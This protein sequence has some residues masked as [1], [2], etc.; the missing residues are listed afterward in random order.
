MLLF[1]AFI[2]EDSEGRWQLKSA[3][4]M[5]VKS[6]PV[7]NTIPVQRDKVRTELLTIVSQIFHNM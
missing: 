3:W 7:V 1:A 6:V 5:F 2:C 4:K